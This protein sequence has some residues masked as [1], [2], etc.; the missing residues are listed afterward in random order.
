MIF[1]NGIACTLLTLTIVAALSAEAHAQTPS[2]RRPQNAKEIAVRSSQDDQS[3]SGPS[4][5]KGLWR[6]VRTLDVVR[7]L[8]K[9]V[10]SRIIDKE[11]T[12]CVDPTQAM[13]ATFSSGSVGSCV[14]DKPEKVGNKY[15]FGHRCD[16]MGAVSTVITVRSDEAYTELN[17]VTTGEHPKTDLVV[18]TRIGDCDDGVAVNS[19]ESPPS[20]LDH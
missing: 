15:T 1:R 7:G 13:K 4:F 9:N 17:E 2:L 8:N 14:S 18:A 6:F 3:F 12:R 10:K 20:H 11:M 19:E 5:R 16:Y